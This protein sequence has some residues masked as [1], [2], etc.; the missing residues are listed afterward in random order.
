MGVG[1]NLGVYLNF[2]KWPS[3]DPVVLPYKDFKKTILLKISS[4]Y[5]SPEILPS[6]WLKCKK[7]FKADESASKLQRS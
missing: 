3:K 4:E 1:G 2:R 6:C 5:E 7:I